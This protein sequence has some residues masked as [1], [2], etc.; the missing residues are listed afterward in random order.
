MRNFFKSVRGMRDIVSSQSELL[1]FVEDTARHLSSLRGYKQIRTPVLEH[2][3]LF[4]NSLSSS[5]IVQKEMFWFLDKSDQKL[6]LR[7]EGTVG[8][9][10][11]LV[12]NGFINNISKLFYLGS[13]YRRERPQKGRYREFYQFGLE[14]IGV[15]NPL[16]DV[17]VI[18]M[19]Y[20]F[21]KKLG[22]HDFEIRLS[23]LGNTKI[24]EAYFGKLTQVLSENLD[25]VPKD[26]Q[27]RVGTNPIRIF[28][29][30]DP[31]LDKF[32][33]SLPVLLDHL[34]DESIGKLEQVK[35][36]LADLNIP[37]VVDPFLVRGLDY[38]SYTAFEYVPKDQD[39][40][41]QSSLGGGGRY[42]D[43]IAM[44]GGKKGFAVGLA[45]GLD[46][47]L[48][49][50]GDLKNTLPL[51]YIA[52]IDPKF[53]NKALAL[54]RKLE[55]DS[56]IFECELEG[57]SL[58][59]QMKRAGKLGAKFVVIVGEK[60]VLK[61]MNDGTQKNVTESSLLHEIENVTQTVPDTRY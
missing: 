31:K 29:Y 49:K 37:F 59:G 22:I 11:A 15:S 10:R 12:E 46:R 40:T 13:M 53:Q 8:V 51:I 5:D 39:L 32:K 38:Y 42:D 28:D 6:S 50:I 45:M 24:R 52:F 36:G 25:Q 48:L 57:R 43:L 35:S 34:D 33:K 20:D 18:A 54:S 27:H 19:G 47:I 2:K 56:F 41:Q 9:I 23:S 4:E 16:A 1:N 7:P 3:E 55:S 60:L 21:L 17:E 44:L 30:K 14:V 61:N 58:K 26:F